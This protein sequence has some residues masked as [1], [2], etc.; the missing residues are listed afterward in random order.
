MGKTPSLFMFLWISV[1]F[2]AIDILE[3]IVHKA[4]NKSVIFHY[5]FLRF[6]IPMFPINSARHYGKSINYY[7]PR[8]FCYVCPFV[9]HT[10]FLLDNFCS[11]SSPTAFK[12]PRMIVLIELKLEICFSLLSLHIIHEKYQ[13]AVSTGVHCCWEPVSKTIYYR[14]PLV[15]N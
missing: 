4:F 6:F 13:S 9:C 15:N 8:C 7:L 14:V 11:I 10:L 2:D 1:H 12:I 3:N 5:E